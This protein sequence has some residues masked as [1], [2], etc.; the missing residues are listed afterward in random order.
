MNS[1]DS[2][3]QRAKE[4]LYEATK[5]LVVGMLYRGNSGLTFQTLSRRFKYKY[6]GH[7]PMSLFGRQTVKSSFRDKHGHGWCGL[8]KLIPD[9]SFK[10]RKVN[11]SRCRTLPGL[12][13]LE[14]ASPRKWGDA[15]SERDDT[16]FHACQLLISGGVLNVN[17]QDGNGN[18]PLHLIASLIHVGDCIYRRARL[19]ETLVKLQPNLLLLNNKKETWVH[20]ISGHRT[21]KWEW[22][23]PEDMKC[24]RE[25]WS[26][27]RIEFLKTI[28][29]HSSASHRLWIKLTNKPNGTGEPPLHVW[30]SGLLHKSPVEHGHFGGNMD[31]EIEYATLLI[32][33]GANVNGCDSHGRTPL[34]ICCYNIRELPELENVATMLASKGSMVD[35]ADHDGNTPLMLVPEESALWTTF[36]TI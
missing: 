15:I 27:Y 2:A 21:C 16:I 13:T 10:K 29:Q 19:V 36:N 28:I 3:D 8:L 30:V 34:H 24:H 31:D 20:I 18:T 22:V 33:Q 25:E 12:G 9:L 35:Q 6:G 11:Y 26:I 7:H 1:Q 14:K 17:R 4:F 32:D 5:E 23:F